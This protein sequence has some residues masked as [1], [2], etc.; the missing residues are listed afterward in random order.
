MLNAAVSEIGTQPDQ[1]AGDNAS[2]NPRNEA[3]T[4]TINEQ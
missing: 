2:A 4:V 1:P 3:A